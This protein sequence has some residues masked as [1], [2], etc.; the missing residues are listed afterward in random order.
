MITVN[1]I[2]TKYEN[3]KNDMVI[4]T[5]TSSNFYDYQT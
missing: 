1:Y 5:I 3:V 4:N 2:C